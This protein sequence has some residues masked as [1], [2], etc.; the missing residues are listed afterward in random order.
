MN[1]WVGLASLRAEGDPLDPIDA[2]EFSGPG[3]TPEWF[4]RQ[5]HAFFDWRRS[6]GE[7]EEQLMQHPFYLPRTNHD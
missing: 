7:P 6:C 2:A 4:E 5:C 3:A 1:L